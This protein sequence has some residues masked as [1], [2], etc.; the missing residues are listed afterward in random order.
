MTN[1]QAVPIFLD[2]DGVIIDSLQIYLELFEHLCERYQRPL[3]IRDAQG[4]RQWYQPRWERNFAE[5]G[6]SDQEYQEVCAY[7]PSVLDYGRAP[8]FEGLG[9]LLADL[10]QRHPLLVMSTAP[11]ASISE[12]LQVGGLAK[13]FS[14]VNGSDDGSTDKIPKIRRLMQQFPSGRGIMVGDT[15]LDIEA[16][17][18]NGLQT[19]GV[20]Y[21]WISEE[22][23]AAA[24]PDRLVSQPE[25]LRTAIASCLDALAPC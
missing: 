3:P 22:R 1:Q 13:F 14:S 19:V 20:S 12:R 9:E 21:G 10:S 4:F 2:W 5:M 7:Y 23:L 15:D 11:T 25:A 17:R 16:G 24:K 6:F 8:F 18:A